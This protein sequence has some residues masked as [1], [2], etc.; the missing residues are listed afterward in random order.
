MNIKRIS[1]IIYLALF[2]AALNGQVRQP[3][4][5]YFMETIPQITQMN[6]A[7]Q[8]RANGY[9]MLPGVNFD[10]RTDIWVR[11][12]LQEGADGKRHLPIE[13][14]YDYDK[15]WSKIGKKSTM[16]NVAGDVDVLGFGFRAGD[17]YFSFGITEHFSA[18]VALPSDLFKIP[19]RGFP[20][21]TTFDFSPL[22]GQ[23]LLYM[24]LRAAYSGRIND[25]LTVGVAVKPIFGQVAAATKIDN[26]K[27]HTSELQWDVKGKGSINFSAPVDVVMKEDEPDKISDFGVRD[28]IDTYDPMDWI[29]NYVTAFNNAG[30]AFDFG[31][32]YQINER[33]NVSASLNNFGFIGWK[34]DLSN[35]TGT[36][37]FPYTGVFYD[38]SGD[39]E[40]G[41]LLGNMA[42][43][44][45]DSMSYSVKH[46]KFRTPLAPVFHAGASYQLTPAISA[47]FLSRTAFWNKGVRQSFNTTLCLQPYS[48]VA[49]NVGATWQLNAGVRLG[50]GFM[51][52][53][54]PLQF[55]LLADNVPVYIP[56]AKITHNE[57]EFEIP[58]LPEGMKTLTLRLG[59]NLVFGRHGYVNRPM[60]NKGKSSWN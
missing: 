10:F 9:V 17:G 35:I 11:E 29:T 50:G 39:D 49:M 45:L 6:P 24:Q 23:A 20:D 44:F 22:R 19:E 1:G 30:V 31:A 43:A 38:V 27:M 26:F 18:N 60:L 51:F 15:L 13:K 12:L 57:S 3:H 59:L 5:L 28:Y 37:D 58:F 16:I 55:Y 36:A 41:D 42:D 53:M 47:G 21:G 52:L 4:S 33:F 14:Q 32:V 46:D 2:C 48:F 54:G 40:F 25:R 56:S 34:N 8:P 7:L